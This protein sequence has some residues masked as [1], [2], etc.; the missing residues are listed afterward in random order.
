[1]PSIFMSKYK[2]TSKHEANTLGYDSFNAN[3]SLQAFFLQIAKEILGYGPV[4]QNIFDCNVVSIT[5]S[6][7]ALSLYFNNN[8]P[9]SR[10]SET[11]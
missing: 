7:S 4:T 5:V 3:S 2:R 9:C 1:M 10:I 6:K 8:N 11:A